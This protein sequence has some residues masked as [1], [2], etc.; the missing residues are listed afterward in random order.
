MYTKNWSGTHPGCLIALIDQS[1]S[2]EDPFGQ[3]QTGSGQR[4]CDAVA[5]VVNRFLDELINLNTTIS[6]NGAVDVRPRADIA[7]V[8]YYGNGTIASALP[9]PLSQQDFVNLQEL[10][11][12]PIRVETRT[13]KEPDGGGNLKDV[14]VPFRIWVEPYADGGTPMLQALRHAKKLA[15]D[16]AASHQDCYPPVILKLTDGIATDSKTTSDLEEEA[17][18]IAQIRTSD[19]AA[20][21]FTIHITALQDYPVEYPASVDE[22]PNDPFAKRLFGLTSAIP[23]SA[24]QPLDTLLGR[25]VPPGA[26]GLIFNGD[27]ESILLMFRFATAPAVLQ[28]DPNR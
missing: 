27:A 11:S 9:S 24:T 5:R 16:W 23:E 15:G 25:S 8:S 18:E 17:K 14:E 12:N 20:L 19:G 1:K 13:K 4:K 10:Q 21:I 6:R 2:M 7:L 28:V 3:S 22:L 26:R